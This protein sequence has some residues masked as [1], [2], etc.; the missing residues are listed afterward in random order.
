MKIE[1]SKPVIFYVTCNKLQKASYI[2]S[3][4]YVVSQVGIVYY[5]LLKNIWLI[6]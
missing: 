6:Y 1:V 4:K 3:N 5:Y 2:I